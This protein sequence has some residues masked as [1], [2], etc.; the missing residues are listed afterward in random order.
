VLFVF[1]DLVVGG[2]ETEVRLLAKNLDP[3]LYRIEVVAC[4]RKLGMPEQTHRQLEEL[5]V[6]LD[7]APYDLTFGET[8]EYLA[9]KFGGY[10]LVVACQGAPHVYPALERLD[11]RRRP[12]LIEH[13]GIV[14]EALEC[15]KHFTTRYVGV[16]A[17]IRDAARSLMPERPHHALEI[18]SMVDLSEFDPADHAGARREL[19]VP[20]GVPLIGW[21]GRLAP[22]KR[23]EVFIRAAAIVSERRPQARYVIV[24]GP[25]VQTP[26]YADELRAL[27]RD[28]ALGDVLTF[29][30][31]RP[32][33]PRLLSGLDAFV[34]VSRD[35]GMPHVIAEAG[36]ARLPVV[37]T[38]DNGSEEQIADGVTG[39]FVPHDSPQ[40]V[41]AALGRLL[42]DPTLRRR[43]GE[44]LR[45]KVER[46]Y[47][48][49]VVV[50]R[51]EALFDEVIAEGSR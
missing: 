2:E 20:E 14:A 43:L 12:P 9:G 15:P 50:R 34:W 48:V 8:V 3:D 24:G 28:L 5:G 36:A 32:D 47:S 25:Y 16:C 39:L 29:L 27:A 35:E 38:R 30:G 18:P 40:A 26:E 21:V 7:G 31:D 17:T 46:E 6:P 41:A 51:W 22:R 4:E 37:A 10:D 23:V 33:V 19:R 45:R 42:E 13:G 11:D 49:A 44:N 1:R